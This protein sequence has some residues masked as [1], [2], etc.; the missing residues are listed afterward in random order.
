MDIRFSRRAFLQTAS[1]ATAA[2]VLPIASHA[3]QAAQVMQPSPQLRN[4]GFYR[5]KLGDF[6]LVSVSDGTLSVPAAGF[7]GNASPNQLAE[8][9]QAG[10]ETETL[11]AHCNVLYVNTGQHRVLI[12]TGNGALSGDTAGKL[13][14]NLQAA[15]INP[16][17]IDTII[18]SHAHGD[19]VGGLLDASGNSVFTNAQFYVPR[20]ENEFWMQPQ[21]SLPKMGLDEAAKQKMIETAKRQ[22]GAI[23]SRLTIFEPEQEIISG[24]S[25]IPASG[26]TPGQVAI[27]IRSGNQFLTHTADVVHTH[28]INLWHPDW[29]P[30]FDADPAQAV[31]A[32]QR[33]LQQISDSRELM[34]A[35]HFPF[36]GLGHI[37][38]RAGGGFTWEPVNWQFET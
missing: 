9:L 25:A 2:M 18:I 13:L 21:V 35:Y 29:Q 11:T 34:Y 38:P 1:L 15:Q 16:A 12:D 30:I 23:Q 6:E 32:R 26:H 10:F 37:R 19:H 4:P 33:I 8:V 24:F 22:L 7:A 17:D 5:F 14:A 27:R 28:H 20:L 36:P 31:E 3:G